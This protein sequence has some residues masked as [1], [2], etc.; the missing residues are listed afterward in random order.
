MLILGIE[1][2][3]D[4]TSASVV[5]NGTTLLS[6]V[7]ATS[8][9]MHQKY[10][11]IIPDRAAREQLISILPVIHETLKACPTPLI[12][13][14][15]DAISITYGPGLIG[16]LLIGVETAKTLAL[17]WNKPLIPINHLIGH[18]YA[19]WISSPALDTRK[20]DL[21]PQFPALV[22]LV[23]GGHSELILMK[24]H[25]NFELLGSTRDDAAGE[26]FDKCGRLLGLPYPYGPFI[27]KEAEKYL[28][29]PNGQKI[30]VKFPRPMIY[31][32]DF[33][34]SF[35]GLKTA[36]L[37]QFK[38]YSPN[39]SPA[40]SS[41]LAYELQ[42]AITDV[43]VSKTLKAVDKCKP[44]SVLIAG[45]VAANKRLREKLQSAVNLGTNTDINLFIPPLK[46][47]TDNA[48]IIASAAFFNQN[49]KPI[50][51]ITADP[52]LNI[53]STPNKA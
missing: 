36:F 38:K 4:E 42:E 39:L 5:E 44:K 9:D 23:S 37:N 3:C 41:C 20:E 53:N 13:S 29:L 35:S 18:I 12:P 16:S 25:G 50:G 47:C 24:A 21:I 46:Y 19:N 10:G 51:Q 26:C 22:L 32:K 27:E 2:S 15:I 28:Q 49:P 48:A 14:D 7:T 45:G 6:L 40:I 8:Q 34:F 30:E 43:L 1:T 33:N 11:G 52:S 17:A 31:E